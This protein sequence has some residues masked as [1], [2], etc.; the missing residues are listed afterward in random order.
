MYKINLTIRNKERR[1]K[2][3][4]DVL[5]SL[6]GCDFENICTKAER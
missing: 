3:L 2:I 5:D 6:M 4:V 1:N